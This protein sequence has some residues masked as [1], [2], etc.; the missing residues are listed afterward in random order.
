MSWFGSPGVLG[1]GYGQGRPDSFSQT[2]T[3]LPDTVM[4]YAA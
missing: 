3:L 2:G 1:R 4:T